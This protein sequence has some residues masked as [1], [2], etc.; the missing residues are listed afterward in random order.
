MPRPRPLTNI[1]SSAI[2]DGNH[3]FSAHQQLTPRTPHSGSRTSRL[4]QGFSKIPLAEADDVDYDDQSTLQSA[5]LL[6]S[7]STA[8]FSVR[9]TRER[10]R[11]SP[12]T[13]NHGKGTFMHPT[14]FLSKFFDRLPLAF[15][16]FM[17]GVL[18]ILIV[19]S[20]TR[21]EALHRYIGAKAPVPISAADSA[22]TNAPA[23]TPSVVTN[24]PPHAQGDIH[25]LSYENYTKFPLTGL[26]YRHECAEIFNGYMKHGDYWDVGK[27]ATDVPHV[28]DESVCTSTIVYMLDGT[29]GLTADLALVA[30]AAALAREVWL[31]TLT[32]YVPIADL[33]TPEKS[34]IFDR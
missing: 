25:V 22:P 32:P 19:L 11:E 26:E 8:R 18:L 34:D 21:P 12:S 30:Q 2:P 16:I 5:P 28:E 13:K 15:G 4:E 10:E 27:M 6:A 17:A 24:H 29:V 33:L 7:S 20:L 31:L 9:S 3:P 14:Q 1:N 23:S